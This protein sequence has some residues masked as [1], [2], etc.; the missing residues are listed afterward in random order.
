MKM[1]HEAHIYYEE[2][3]QTFHL[4]NDF[5]SYIFKVDFNGKLIQLYYGKK[6]THRSSFN[7]LLEQSSRPMSP[8]LSEQ[9]PFYSYDNLKQELPEYGRSD[10]RKAGIKVLQENGSEITDLV[11][12]S[13]RIFKGKNILEGL[14]A[15][16]AENINECISLAI[17]L[18]D[19]LLQLEVILNYTVFADHSALARSTCIVNYGQ[20][21]LLLTRLMSLNLDLP[22]KEYDW[23]QLSGAWGRERHFVTKVL[24]YGVVEISSNR[25]HSS[26]NHNPFVTLKRKTTTEFQGEAIGAMFVYSGNFLIQAEVDA[27]DVTRLQMGMNPESF[28]W[29]LEPGQSFQS[30][31]VLLVYS[32][33]GLNQMS[34][35]YH[36]LL[37]SRVVRGKWRHKPRPIVL[38]NWEATYFDFNEE[39]LL[40]IVE[41]GKKAGVELFVLD[42]GWFGQRNNDYTGLGDWVENKEKLPEGL[43]GLA[44]KVNDLG[45]AFGLWIEPEMINKDSDL[46]RNHPEWLLH[47]PG[48]K[49]S[50]GR[51][52]YVLNFANEEVVTYLFNKISNLL[53]SA[54]ITYI[55]W[56]MNRSISEA[57]DGNRSSKQQGEVHHRYILGVYQLY[58]QL[59]NMFPEVL[60]ESCASGGGRF[61]A[62]MLYYAPQAWTSD[63]SDAIDRLSIQYGTSLAYPLSSIGAHVSIVPNHQVNR[64]TSLN[65]RGNVAY[66]GAFGYE[67]DLNRL[68]ME[69]FTEVKKQ[70]AFVKEY[71]ALLQYG[72]FYRLASPFEGNIISWMVVSQDKKQTIVGYY[73]KLNEVNV[74][75]KRVRLLGLEPTIKYQ[76]K[77]TSQKFHGDELMNIGLLTTD[78]SSGQFQPSLGF[79]E[80]VDFDSRIFILEAVE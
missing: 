38:N 69:E 70:I 67:L 49:A 55:K 1:N 76:L 77:G 6:V 15:S 40:S 68:S 50:P 66:F 19:E 16:Y 33:K 75:F 57:F 65:T 71:R 10:F 20:E 21:E 51:Q 43:T 24:D 39:K 59:T 44:K 28:S 11:Y 58:E 30:P 62:G 35:T 31:E 41:K 37:N 42:D 64:L 34:Q 4:Q 53:S 48:R 54:N 26:H 12:Q 9:H 63:N 27:Y 47:T 29:L 25:G 61:D 13:H 60:F 72:N 22:D 14:P 45:M 80:S 73:K 32:N 8:V 56:D 79:D 52:Q 2:E 23:M 36:N 74:S 3:E 7:Y 78:A 46:Y 18:K 17:T 5:F